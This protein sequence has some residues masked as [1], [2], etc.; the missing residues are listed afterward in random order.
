MALS[1]DGLR[2]LVRFAGSPSLGRGLLDGD[3]PSFG[4]GA[5]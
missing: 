1:R 2:I 3:S 5:K 4:A